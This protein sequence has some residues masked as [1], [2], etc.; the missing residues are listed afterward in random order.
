LILLFG[1]LFLLAKATWEIHGSL[2]GEE[3]GQTGGAVAS[4][5]AVIA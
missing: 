3:H 5:G 4:F 2:E 1:G